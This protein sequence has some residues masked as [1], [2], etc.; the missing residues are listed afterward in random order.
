MIR[1]PPRSTRTATLF[2]YTTLFR[3]QVVGGQVQSTPVTDGATYTDFLPSMNL[4]VEF[5]D[6]TFLRFGAA[7]MLARA[8]MD[9]LRPGGGVNFDAPRRNNTDIEATPRQEA[10]RVG[11]KDVSPCSTRGSR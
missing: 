9:Q 11:K 7:R 2:P 1:R 3:S 8:R 4:T 5:A 10:R 6:N